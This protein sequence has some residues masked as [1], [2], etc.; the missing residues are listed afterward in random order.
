MNNDNEYT[1]FCPK[2]GNEMKNTSRYCMKCGY[3]NINHP[4][5]KNVIKYFEDKGNTI[6]RN[7]NGTYIMS[8]D[9]LKSNDIDY[10]K[11]N[12]RY[13]FIFNLITFLLTFVCF[14]IIYYRNNGGFSN[15]LL[16]NVWSIFIVIPLMYIYCYAYELLFIKMGYSW[17]KALIPIYNVMLISK[18]VFDNL[19]LGL[20]IIVPI[21][22]QIYL[23]VLMYKLATK[24]NRNGLL[25]VLFPFIMIPLISFS[26]DLY[27]KENINVDFD[28]ETTYGMKKKF[29]ILCSIFLFI[30]L[31]MFLFKFPIIDFFKDKWNEVQSLLK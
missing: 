17:W 14:S 29:L 8:S 7:S 19:F 23:L 15:I 3:L 24:F 20:L 13:C 31:F 25:M 9:I 18:K 28:F 26:E 30:G 1:V 22:G 10:L 27:E 6:V 2:C 21:V 4:N 5:N 16:S 11:R 12:S